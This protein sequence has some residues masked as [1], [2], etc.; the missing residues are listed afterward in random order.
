MFIMAKDHIHTDPFSAALDY[1]LR[2]KKYTNKRFGDLVGYSGAMIDA[3]RHERSP[4][5]ETK[6]RDMAKKLGFDYE[7]FIKEGEALLRQN[8]DIETG[9]KVISIADKHKEIIDMFENKP[10]ALEI[11]QILLQIERQNPSDLKLAKELI[12]VLVVDNS[13]GSQKKRS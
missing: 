10:L 7:A 5:V 8:S 13:A 12:S 9:P 2:V 3:I 11:N 1:Y 6:R 4:G